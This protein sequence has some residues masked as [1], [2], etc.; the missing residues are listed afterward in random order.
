M[1]KWLVT[2]K[3]RLSENEAKKFFT[4]SAFDAMYQRMN[5]ETAK[6][7][8]CTS[9]VDIH[10]NLEL[11]RVR[12]KQAKKNT[13]SAKGSES[14]GTVITPLNAVFTPSSAVKAGKGSM[15]HELLTLLR[16]AAVKKTEKNTDPFPLRGAGINMMGGTGGGMRATTGMMGGVKP[17]IGGGKR[18]GMGRG[19]DER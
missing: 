7:K 9:A 4:G 17:A 11:D 19:R 12:G 15:E 1:Y 14:K 18:G 10:H 3:N 16:P 13:P 5:S 2:G 6:G 8:V